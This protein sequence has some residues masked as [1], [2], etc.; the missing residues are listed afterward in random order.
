[1]FF[2]I[3]WTSQFDH[4]KALEVINLFNGEHDFRAFANID[5]EERVS[6]TVRDIQIDLRIPDYQ[7]VDVG[8]EYPLTIYE[9]S[10]KS[11][12]FLRNQVSMQSLK[13]L[14]VYQSRP[15]R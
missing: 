1:M 3:A 5:K 9:L 12:S 13:A 11:K 14:D 7:G 15:E 8:R 10:F 6:S 4:G 2:S